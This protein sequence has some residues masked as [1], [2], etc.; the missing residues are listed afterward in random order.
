MPLTDIQVRSMKPDAKPFRKSDGGGLFV[1]VRPNGSKLWRM[2]YRHD[3]KQKLLSFGAYP[4]TTL[5]RARAK[6]QQAKT[7]LADGLDPMASAKAEQALQRALSEHTF[8]KIADELVAKG[9][10]DGLAARTIE[11]KRWVL[12]MAKADLGNLPIESIT[13]AEVLA[14]LRKVEAKGNYETAKRMRSTIGQVFRYAVAT[15]RATND[16]TFGLRGAL[17]TPKTVHLSALTDWEDFA[18]LIRAVWGYQSGAP[19]TRTALK[20]MALLYPRPGELR[21]AKW[22]EFD[23]DAAT[24]SIPKERM[25]MRRP[26]VKPLPTQ[27]IELLKEL[28]LVN[29]DGD[30]VFPSAWA[31]SKPISDNTMNTALRR[32]GFTK[33]ECTSHGFRASASSLLNESGKWSPDAIEAELAHVGADEIRR[34]YHRATYWEERVKMAQW[35]ADKVDKLW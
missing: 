30:L 9:E 7:L 20:L 14:V 16:P 12:S 28:R 22:N 4:D 17:I 19:E 8:G 21:Q 18:G 13:A 2:A 11:K 6:R 1:E 5:A 3:G 31:N 34:A 35:W 32:M 10:K 33:E 29:P 25:K 26:H 15:A 24:W 27:A 23:L